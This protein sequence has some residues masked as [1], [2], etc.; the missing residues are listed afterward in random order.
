MNA[1]GLRGS[2][3]KLSSNKNRGDRSNLPGLSSI[4]C[5]HYSHH[6]GTQ[7]CQ[8]WSRYPAGKKRM[9]LLVAVKDI[10]LFD[11]E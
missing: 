5:V 9:T 8:G 2:C 11:E 10:R 1:T 7:T 3:G 4:F 6:A